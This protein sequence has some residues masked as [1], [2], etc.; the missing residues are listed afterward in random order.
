MEFKA[1]FTTAV[2]PSSI[3]F[4]NT[5]LLSKLSLETVT[6][7]WDGTKAGNPVDRP[8]TVRWGSISH[9]VRWEGT[10]DGTATGGGQ[11]AEKTRVAVIWSMECPPI[12]AKISTKSQCSIAEGERLSVVA[13]MIMSRISMTAQ[14]GA[15][16]Y[17]Y[18]WQFLRERILVGAA[19]SCGAGSAAGATEAGWEAGA[20]EAA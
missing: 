10:V 11:T 15:G 19:P 6:V 17:W 13:L 4:S 7:G 8:S 12:P 14:Q 18:K 9:C 20:V 5:K 2:A 3:I 1:V 16:N